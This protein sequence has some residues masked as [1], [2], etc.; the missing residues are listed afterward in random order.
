MGLTEG[1]C[2]QALGQG[3]APAC[4]QWTDAGGRR[5]FPGLQDPH[6]HLLSGGIDLA[7]A[8]YLYDVAGEVT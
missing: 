5:V 1:G 6:I 4:S 2:L 7:T 8:A 3:D